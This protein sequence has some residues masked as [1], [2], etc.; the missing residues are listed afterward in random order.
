MEC[1]QQDPPSSSNGSGATH[2]PGSS[3]R[4]A[5]DLAAS[6]ASSA[7]PGSPP[8]CRKGRHPMVLPSDSSDDDQPSAA[9]PRK[10]AAHLGGS[11]AHGE[12]PAFIPAS[13]CS[14]HAVFRA[15]LTPSPLLSGPCW[16]LARGACM[17]R[18]GR[19]LLQSRDVR[20][21]RGHAG[22]GSSGLQQPWPTLMGWLMCRDRERSPG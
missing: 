16:R 13:V 2:L 9:P 8:P 14:G 18:R 15:C 12:P 6:P 19:L 3:S 22:H 1:C 20:W 21:Q 10:H 7:S 11:T 5:L 4:H 17:R